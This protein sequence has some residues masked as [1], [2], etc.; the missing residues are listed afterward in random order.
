MAQTRASLNDCLTTLNARDT[1][2]SANF[3]AFIHT[4]G[5]NAWNLS[6][7]PRWGSFDR[8]WQDWERGWA[9][10]ERETIDPLLVW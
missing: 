8:G 1:Q 4:G 7:E 2:V 6:D 3:L 10:P 9:E 5:E